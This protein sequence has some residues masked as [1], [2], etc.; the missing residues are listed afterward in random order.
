MLVSRARVSD[1]EVGLGDEG[2]QLLQHGGEDVHREAGAVVLHQGVQQRQTGQLQRSLV[3]P[4]KGGENRQ[5]V[6]ENNSQIDPQWR[7]GHQDQSLDG[8]Q[9]RDLVLESV[10]EYRETTG[11]LALETVAQVSHDLTHAGDGSLLHFLVDILGLHGTKLVR[12]NKTQ[13]N[14]PSV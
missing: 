2:R 8:G 14:I 11:Q 12:S 5:T 9:P 1:V 10:Q 4:Q 3:L 6:V 7:G 13:T